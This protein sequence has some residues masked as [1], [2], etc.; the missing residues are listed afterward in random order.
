MIVIS[1]PASL[2]NFAFTNSALIPDHSDSYITPAK[3]E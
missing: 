1:R 2:G 3:S